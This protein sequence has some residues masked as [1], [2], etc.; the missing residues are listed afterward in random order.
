MSVFNHGHAQALFRSWLEFV[1]E[2]RN[3]DRSAAIERSTIAVIFAGTPHRGSDKAKW[4]GLATRMAS[5]I[6]KD[7]SSRLS[8]A[9]KQGSDVVEQLQ[10]WFKKI[11]N[12][13]HVFSFFEEV[14]VHKIGPIVESESA[15]IHCQH[16]KRRM[17][18][19]NHMEMVRFD[20]KDCN[21]YKKVRDAFKQIHQHEVNNIVYRD[22]TQPPRRVSIQGMQPGAIEDEGATSSSR[23]RLAAPPQQRLLEHQVSQMSLGH[24]HQLSVEEIVEPASQQ[25][26][27]RTSSGGGLAANNL[28][29]L[30]HRA[31]TTTLATMTSTHSRNSDHSARSNEGRSTFSVQSQSQ[32]RAQYCECRLTHIHQSAFSHTNDAFLLNV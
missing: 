29:H 1:S 7:H 14:P 19:A 6:Q 8:D 21:E 5:I 2:S 9:L 17:I 18:H 3:K 28:A 22:V 20:H 32:I 23:Q 25:P 10:D 30:A 13:F 24:G 27:H 31:S 15:A 26:Y 4:A 12:N 11:E 16:E